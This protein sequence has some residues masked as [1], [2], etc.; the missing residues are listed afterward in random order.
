MFETKNLMLKQIYKTLIFSFLA[1]GI[2]NAQGFESGAFGAPV[3]K[4]TRISDQSALIIGGKWGWVINKRFAI[5]TGFY[6]LVTGN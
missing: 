5:G 6:S 3:I 1:F 4:Y 2:S